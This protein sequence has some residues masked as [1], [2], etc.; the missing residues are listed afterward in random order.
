MGHRKMPGLNMVTAA[1]GCDD[2]QKNLKGAY[3]I[4]TVLLV[5]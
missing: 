1:I 3:L 5:P 4:I 2:V